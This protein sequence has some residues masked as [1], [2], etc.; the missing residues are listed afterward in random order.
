MNA[1]KTIR[2]LLRSPSASVGVGELVLAMVVSLLAAAL[3]AGLYRLFYEERVTG[4][5]VHRSFLLIG[6]A[7]TTLFLAIQFSLPLSLGLVGALSIVRFRTPIKDPEEIGFVM[8]VIAASLVCATFRYLLLVLLFGVAL[9]GLLVR[10][11]LPSALGSRRADGVLLVTLEAGASLP[12]LDRVLAV[13]RERLRNPR[14]QSLSSAEGLATLHYSFTDLAP[15][16]L[17]HLEAGLRE[18]A[19]VRKIDVFYNRDGLGR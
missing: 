9:I 11:F 13:V 16:G 3:A 14:L 10:R 6:P 7:V 8:L 2:D 1:L 17:E 5:R 12:P 19:P 15:Q 4:S 18:I